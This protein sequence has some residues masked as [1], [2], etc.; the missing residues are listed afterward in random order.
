MRSPS[1]NDKDQSLM[2]SATTGTASI[3]ATLIVW[4]KEALD[5]YL[6]QFAIEQSRHRCPCQWH[7]F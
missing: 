5:F 7:C 6:Q 1:R 4:R 3:V 2:G